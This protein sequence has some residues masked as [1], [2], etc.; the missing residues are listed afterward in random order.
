VMYD[1]AKAVAARGAVVFVPQWDALAPDSHELPDVARGWEQAAAAIVFA[2]ANAAA[3]GGDAGRLIA[4]GHSWG[5]SVAAAMTLA[6]DRFKPEAT[7]AGV[8]AL[9]DAC[10]ALDGPMDLRVLVPEARYAGDAVK[11][12]RL[13]PA[14]IAANSPSREGV[15][16]RLIVGSWKE[17][18]ASNVSF[19]DTLK[20]AGYGVS[21]VDV[22]KPHMEMA[23]PLDETLD[24]IAEL[25]NR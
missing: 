25:A 16:F 3:Y 23:A 20:R 12:N 10:V 22:G 14:W 2:R 7:E 8:S 6:G 9:P 4:V 18:A 17:G 21:L 11:W 5:A 15:E 13:N 19:E 24:A 1:L